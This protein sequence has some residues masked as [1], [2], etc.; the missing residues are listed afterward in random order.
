MGLNDTYSQIWSRILTLDPLPSPDPIFNMVVQEEN[1]KSMMPRQGD[2]IESAN[3]FVVVYR[4]SVQSTVIKN[5]SCRH[6]RRYG[7]EE[8]TCY[9]LIE[10]PSDWGSRKGEGELVPAEEEGQATRG[11]V[12]QAQQLIE[13]P[14]DWGSR[15]RECEVMLAEGKG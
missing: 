4:D 13:Y 7:Q 12:G 11:D 9:E 10:Y 1:H 6:Y 15:K 2:M 5:G 8:S 14:P 3:A